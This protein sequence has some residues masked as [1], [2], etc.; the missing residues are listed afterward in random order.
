VVTP[1]IR[2]PGD[3]PGD[4]SRYAT[5]ADAA[6]AGADYIVVGRSITAAKDPAAAF[7]AVARSFA[8]R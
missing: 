3:D 8:G 4:Q 7:D 1:G 2:L 5:P 6:R